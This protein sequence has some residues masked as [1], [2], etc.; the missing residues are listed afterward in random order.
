MKKLIIF[1][2]IISSF[3]FFSCEKDDKLSPQELTGDNLIYVGAWYTDGFTKGFDILQDGTGT[4]TEMNGTKQLTIE[5]NI[6][7]TES[8]ISI[9][10]LKVERTLTIDKAPTNDGSGRYMILNGETYYELTLW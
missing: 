8:Q 3:I 9:K 4:W 10:A 1:L 2:S 6:T 7:I 5:G